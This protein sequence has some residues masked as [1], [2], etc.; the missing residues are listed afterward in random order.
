MRA[1]DGSVKNSAAGDAGSGTILSF[2][3]IALA[4]SVFLL[5]QTLAFNLIQ[6]RRLEATVDSMAIGAADAL[7]GLNTG[8]PCPTATQIGLIN[9]VRLDT[10]RIVGF[11]AFISAHLQ[12]V[13][14]VLSAQALAG[15]S[16]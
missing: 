9:G 3:A 2:A 4:I 15:P 12:G 10:C 1:K 5:S 11:E 8:F 13:G 6:H 7:R 14:V 16:Y